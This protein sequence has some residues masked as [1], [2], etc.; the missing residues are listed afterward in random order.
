MDGEMT[1]KSGKGTEAKKGRPEKRILKIDASPEY[2]AKA[3]FEAV[4]S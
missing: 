2:V 3:V 1:N 4:I